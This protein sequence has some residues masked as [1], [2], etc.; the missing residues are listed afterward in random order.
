MACKGDDIYI[1]SVL[2][3]WSGKSKRQSN[4]VCEIQVEEQFSAM[5][6]DHSQNRPRMNQENRANYANVTLLVLK[7]A[8]MI[9]QMYLRK[10]CV[11]VN[12]R[13]LGL[14]DITVGYFFITRK[15]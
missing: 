2:L 10:C 5:R 12:I 14:C 6:S 15:L 9:S 13:I 1:S 11:I 7:L 3:R 4:I 8:L